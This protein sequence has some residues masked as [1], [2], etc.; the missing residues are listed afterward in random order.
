MLGGGSGPE[1]THELKPEVDTIREVLDEGL[2]I[3]STPALRTA[4][5][6]NLAAEPEAQA[7]QPESS[8][9]LRLS[10]KGLIACA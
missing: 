3:L 7:P 1:L 8:V 2:R 10:T 6:L 9:E 5:Q 4:Y